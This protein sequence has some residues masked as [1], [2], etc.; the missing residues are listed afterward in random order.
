MKAREMSGE[1]IWRRRLAVVYI[2]M[3]SI[4]GVQVNNEE[5]GWMKE[6]VWPQSP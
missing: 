6:L 1:S 2:A 5:A 4:D 3:R